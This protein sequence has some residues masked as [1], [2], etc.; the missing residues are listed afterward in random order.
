MAAVVDPL[1]WLVR[2]RTDQSEVNAEARARERSLRTGRDER[3]ARLQRVAA[4]G[5]TA[6]D[7]ERDLAIRQC[8]SAARLQSEKR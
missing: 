7:V 4:G 1:N 5:P 8:A 2:C 6:D 3:G